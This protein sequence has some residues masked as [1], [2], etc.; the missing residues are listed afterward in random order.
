VEIK[1]IFKMD[2]WWQR[3][4]FCAQNGREVPENCRK[5]KWFRVLSVTET[6]AARSPVWEEAKN[7]SPE[8]PA[9]RF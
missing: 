1:A 8:G 5:G 4:V 2:D 6:A 7:L 3:D 9:G